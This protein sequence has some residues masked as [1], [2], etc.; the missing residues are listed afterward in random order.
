MYMWIVKRCTGGYSPETPE[1]RAHIINTMKANGLKSVYIK[2]ADGINSY[3]LRDL[4]NKNYVDDIL[5]A[6]FA[7]LK[8][9]GIPAIGWQYIYGYSPEKEA[10]KAAAR[11][12]Q[13]DLDGFVLDP[14]AEMKVH[15]ASASRRYMET[16]RDLTEVP[17]GLSSYRYPSYHADFPWDGF[18][19]YMSADM[20]DAHIPQVYWI[21]D[22]RPT[23]PA[24]Q[25]KRSMDELSAKLDL[26]FAPAGAAYGE[27]L[28]SGYWCVS[29]KQIANFA[30]AARELG[31]IGMSWWEWGILDE[32][33]Y[34]PALWEEIIKQSK[35]WTGETPPAPE[36][37][38]EPPM[39]QWSGNARG[40]YVEE[41]HGVVDPFDLYEYDF[42]VSKNWSG[43]DKNVQAAYDAG[44]PILLFYANDPELYVDMNLGSW[45]EPDNDPQIKELDRMLKMASG[46]MRKV[47]GI[48]LDCSKV[49]MS[50]GKNLTA[51]WIAEHGK[52][53]VD[54]IWQRYKLPIWMYMNA[55]PLAVWPDSQE[56]IGWIDSIGVSTVSKVDEAGGFPADGTKPTLP[57]HGENGWGFW[58]YSVA[59][60]WKFLYNGDAASLYKMLNFTP[61]DTTPTDPPDPGD[62]DDEPPVVPTDPTEFQAA[63]L[64]LLTE[65]RDNQSKP[66]KITME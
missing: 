15:G 1:A 30:E 60:D 45:P 4:G 13:F 53:M 40:W 5:P 9:A 36:E 49:R 34:G 37:P 58:L 24:E 22:N 61:K 46:A 12:K 25:L 65:I 48:I 20:G 23:G 2:V 26:P 52:H 55:D 38:E 16:L 42:L 39:S 62:D 27:Q 35:S 29:P 3:N 6:L 56:I 51:T 7:D 8:A 59:G 28:T 57:Y 44:K 66:R 33:S 21:G 14:E 63:V 11:I 47:H 10:Q 19:D 41:K 17:L 50:N 18:L 31:C 43:F 54:M 64:A 32:K